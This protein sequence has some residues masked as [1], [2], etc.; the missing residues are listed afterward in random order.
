[1]CNDSKTPAGK[2]SFSHRQIIYYYPRLLV[3]CVFVVWR[4]PRKSCAL[5]LAHVPQVVK[6]RRACELQS[7]PRAQGPGS[8]CRVLRFYFYS[9]DWLFSSGSDD[10]MSLSCSSAQSAA[11]LTSHFKVW[12][13][14]CRWSHVTLI[15]TRAVPCHAL[16]IFSPRHT[17]WITS[18]SSWWIEM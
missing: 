4:W 1:M 6:G 17:R 15:P 5:F 7:A 8:H 14:A 18:L 10:L 12:L 3:F 13:V 9:I 11:T 2:Y 16:L